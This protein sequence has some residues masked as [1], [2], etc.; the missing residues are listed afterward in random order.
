MRRGL[1]G[2]CDVSGARHCSE[3][4]KKC[5]SSLVN[6]VHKREWVDVQGGPSSGNISVFKYRCDA[7]P[8]VHKET[9]VHDRCQHRNISDPW[10]TVA[11]KEVVPNE[12]SS[13]D[14]PA[15]G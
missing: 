3:G 12:T 6:S 7:P 15:G 1:R 5:Y 9:R 14:S 4:I 10:P 11:G 2:F 13:M 8:E